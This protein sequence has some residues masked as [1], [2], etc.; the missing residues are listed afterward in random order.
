MSANNITQ[1]R[2]IFCSEN[3]GHS[4]LLKGKGLNC[5]EKKRSELFKGEKINLLL[6]HL[7]T[8]VIIAYLKQSSFFVHLMVS[9]GLERE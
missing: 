7:N 5:C 3:T 2:S 4:Y 8:N 6:S 1:K 9:L